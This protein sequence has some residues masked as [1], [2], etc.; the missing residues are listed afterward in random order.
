[1]NKLF[2][3]LVRGASVAALVAGVST[4]AALPASADSTS[5]TVTTSYC[6]TAIIP[7]WVGRNYI[8]WNLDSSVSG[9]G[10]SWEVW[11]YQTG[12]LVGSGRIGAF[13]HGSGQI[14]GLY[15]LYWMQLYNCGPS[16][17][18]WISNQ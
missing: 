10:C 15:G 13:R 2:K 1:M 4:V 11:D 12:V 16:A 3:T 14:N 5:C 18:G 17:F 7:S 6:S 8:K 9:I